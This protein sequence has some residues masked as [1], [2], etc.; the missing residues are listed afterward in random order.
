MEGVINPPPPPPPARGR[1]ATA[2]G[3]GLASGCHAPA[4]ESDL[5]GWLNQALGSSR[6]APVR[7][8]RRD[9]DQMEVAIGRDV[10]PWQFSDVPPRLVPGLL[11]YAEVI[12]KLTKIAE[13]K[14]FYTRPRPLRCLIHLDVTCEQCYLC[15]ERWFWSLEQTCVCLPTCLGTV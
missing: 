14:P 4:G 11:T 2:S 15:V 6:Y 7:D 12:K 13:F 8:V 5:V 10:V 3:S 9:A 1:H